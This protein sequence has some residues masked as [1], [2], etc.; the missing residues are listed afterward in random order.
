VGTQ[1]DR[2]KALAYERDVLGRFDKIFAAPVRKKGPVAP[3]GFFTDRSGVEFLTPNVPSAQLRF[4]Q[5]TLSVY[6]A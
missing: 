3:P 4:S 1:I 6:S 2:K 5:Y